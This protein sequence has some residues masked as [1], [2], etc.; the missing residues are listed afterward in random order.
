MMKRPLMVSALATAL[1]LLAGFAFAADPALAQDKVQVQE[2][3]YGSQLMTPEERLDYRT[4]MRAAKTADERA[5]IREEHHERMK[6]RATERGVTLPDEP[7]VT[8]RGMGSGTGI[9]AGTGGM[10]RGGAGNR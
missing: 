8:G 1:T 9:G 5:Q 10:G 4:R 3:V 6:L 7:P 2:Q